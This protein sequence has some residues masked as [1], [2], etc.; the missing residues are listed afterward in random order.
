[1]QTGAKSGAVPLIRDQGQEM[2]TKVNIPRRE[3]EQTLAKAPESLLIPHHVHPLRSS[4]YFPLI[5]LEWPRMGEN[6]SAETLDFIR[7]P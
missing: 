2:T 1:M 4:T 7:I 3:P 6:G 5:S